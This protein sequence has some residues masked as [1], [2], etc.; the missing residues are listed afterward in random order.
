MSDS[1]QILQKQDS[2]FPTLL[3]EIHSPPERLFFRGKIPDAHQICVAVVGTRKASHYGKL[4]TRKLIGELARHNIAIVSGLAYGIDVEAHRA[5]LEAGGRTIAVLAGGIDNPS[6]S[7]RA[8]ENLANEIIASGGCVLS[9]HP[10]GTQYRS[11]HF[12]ARN[13][14]IAGMCKA[15]IIVES[16]IKSGTMITAAAALRENR[17]VM[18]VPGPITSPLSAGPHQLL[19][20]G[21]IPITC[22]QDILEVLD[23]SAAHAAA[24]IKQAIPMSDEERSLLSLITH[25]PVNIDEIARVSKGTIANTTQLITLLELKSLITHV[26]SGCYT[27]T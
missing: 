6:I 11:Y 3:S 4:V 7:P 17:D 20:D 13:R 10:T 1:I 2:R 23:L 22:V 24:D 21:A 5:T 27:K 19:K 15:T 26:G 9:E 14:I 18:I 25:E 12:P 8:H 16:T